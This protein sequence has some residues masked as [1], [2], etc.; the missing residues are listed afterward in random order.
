LESIASE[1]PEDECRYV[2]YDF[3]TMIDGKR[4]IAKTLLIF[5]NPQDAQVKLKF[6]YGSSKIPIL[7]SLQGVQL[8]IN[9]ET[10]ADVI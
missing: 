4:K 1:L 2:F 9:A 6:A 7:N 5:W 10:Q 8:E 3:N